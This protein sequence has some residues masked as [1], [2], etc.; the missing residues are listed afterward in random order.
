MGTPTSTG[1]V[2]N[3]VSEEEISIVDL[4]NQ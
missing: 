3:S 4:G 2:F 1:Q